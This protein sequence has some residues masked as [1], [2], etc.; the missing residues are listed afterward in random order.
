MK[1]NSEN[2]VKRK[3]SRLGRLILFLIIS[4]VIFVG[5]IL[6]VR[7]FG[8][9][10][11]TTSDISNPETSAVISGT[12]SSTPQP[13]SSSVAAPYTE[14]YIQPAGADW[15][16]RLVNKWNPLESDFQ[17]PL[18]TYAGVNK[19]DSRAIDKLKAIVQ[20]SNGKIR[21]ASL[22]RS[23]ELQTSLFNREVTNYVRE[24]LSKAD[25]EEKAAQ[26]VARPGTSEHNLGLA[27]DFLFEG[28]SSLSEDYKNTETYKWMMENCAKYG[29]IL[30][31]PE[32]KKSITGVMFEPWHY[33]YVGEEAAQEIMSRGITLEE[34][35]HEKGK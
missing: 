33:R 19:F 28:Y 12:E 1:N 3:S 8:D 23:I 26:A 9:Y 10:D 35:L 13:T 2:S 31:F 5:I 15:N 25:A 14:P 29:F 30:R 34:Y 32:N 7:M 27:V 4:L 21:V 22:H 20:A 24:G 17:P 16:L 6:S 11:L 18:T